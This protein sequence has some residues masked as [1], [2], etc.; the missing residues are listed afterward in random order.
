MMTTMRWLP[1]LV[2]LSCQIPPDKLD[3]SLRRAA[4]EA[5][6]RGQAW[7]RRDRLPDGT[8]RPKSMG[9]R[10]GIA[11]T[12]LAAWALGADDAA[13]KILAPD[14]LGTVGRTAA[15]E[16]EFP[17]YATALSILAGVGGDREKEY[18]K[19]AHLTETLGFHPDSP[20]YGGWDYGRPLFRQ[21]FR[22]DLSVTSFVID[23]LRGE[24]PEKARI[25]VERCQDPDS[26]GF[27]FAPGRSKAGYDTAPD[28]KAAPRPYGS[29]T[30]DGIRS[31]LNLGDSP[32]S[33]R[34]QAALRWIQK[35]FTVDRNPGFEKI[36]DRLYE[37]ALLYYYLQSLSRSLRAVGAPFPWREAV[38]RK[39]VALQ[40]PD[41]SW[42]NAEGTEFTLEQEP[43]VAT[44]F[45][46]VALGNALLD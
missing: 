13:R 5:I 31:L 6:R 42:Q 23:A 32:S 46:L 2:L 15:G 40:R 38:I 16:F 14:S 45:A 9:P 1:G 18:L 34:V 8:W 7:L 28:G 24:T 44:S 19:S 22:W 17:N 27:F 25:F 43:V 10:E 30:C 41:G 12:A 39:L 36:E 26:G 11:F 35:N 3:P 21:A 29:M 4:M 33:A 37:R 20:E